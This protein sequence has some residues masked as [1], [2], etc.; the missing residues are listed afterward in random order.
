MSEDRRPQGWDIEDPPRWARR[1]VWQ[2]LLV[3]GAAFVLVSLLRTLRGLILWLVYALFLSLALEP[4]VDWLEKHGWR[5]GLSALLLLSVLGLAFVGML[6]M[7]IPILIDAISL[8]VDELPSWI[9]SLNRFTERCCNVTVDAEAIRQALQSA[10]V[11]LASLA[12][13]ALGVLTGTVG[14]LLNGAFSAF[15]V[16]LFAFYIV[17]QAP[18]VRRSVLSLLPPRRQEEVLYIWETA[19]EKMG[20]YLYSRL[21]LAL[22]NGGLFYV[23]LLIVDMPFALPL[24]LFQGFVA[25]FIPIV[26][27]YIAVLVPALIALI[28]APT[29]A[30]IAIIAYALIYQ[31]VEN[32][33]LSPKISAKTMSLHPAVALGAGIAGG[34]IGGLLWAFVA[35]P[36]AATIQ[37]ALGAYVERH[38]VIESELTREREVPSR[39]SSGWRGAITRWR[40][41]IRGDDEHGDDERGD[42]PQ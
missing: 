14:S 26:G 33:W 36:V 27:T 4:A 6:L 11:S 17:A 19:I 1:L 39:D 18:R 31:Q 42:E 40:R 8:I 32:Y 22:I 2:T 30:V 21:A 16:G 41:K 29:Y 34:A 13:N 25:A 38:E 7:V 20:G 3:I 24:A 12:G 15:T 10:D 28:A 23:L 37:A 5:R 35:L 9:A